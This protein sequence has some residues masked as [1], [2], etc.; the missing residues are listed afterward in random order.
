MCALYRIAVQGWSKEAAIEEMVRGGYGFH[1]VWEN[2]K[3]YVAELDIED[4]KRRAGL[5]EQEPVA[6]SGP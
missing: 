3:E 1:G 6:T 5:P 4:I 2:L